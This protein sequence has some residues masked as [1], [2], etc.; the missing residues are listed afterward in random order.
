MPD[1]ALHYF[2]ALFAAIAPLRCCQLLADAA[3][4][5]AYADID[6]PC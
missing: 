5:A 6:T 2:M 1:I 3:K 4:D